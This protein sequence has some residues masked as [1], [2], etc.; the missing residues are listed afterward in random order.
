[1]FYQNQARSLWVMV[2]VFLLT[3]AASVAAQNSESLATI[4]TPEIAARK[5]VRQTEIS[6]LKKN[7]SEAIATL[8]REL[9][10]S[11]DNPILY[12]NLGAAY[13]RQQ[14]FDEAATALEKAIALKPDFPNAFYNLSIVY[15]HLERYEEALAAVQ[16]AVALAPANEDSYVEMCQLYLAMKKFKEAVPCYEAL[17]K[18]QSPNIKSRSFYGIALIQSNQYEKAFAVLKEN[19]E[20]FPD[21][22]VTHNALG[23]LYF[24]KK[25]YKQAIENF[26]RALEINADF[27]PARYNLALTQILVNDKDS[28]L[29]QYVLLKNSNSSFA[30]PLYRFI[31]RDK[32]VYAGK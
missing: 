13:A 12:N 29:K 10:S 28:A 32:I 27:E 3:T 24:K 17:I 16:K 8:K 15:D 6:D 14:K 7:F 26:N 18:R 11:P 20:L 5:N 25:K 31:Y 1:M 19:T 30:E 23:L 2:V 9:L 22:A 4:S 21:K